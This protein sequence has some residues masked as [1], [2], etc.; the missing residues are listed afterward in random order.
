ML[1]H[2]G[3]R[4]IFSPFSS[5]ACGTGGGKSGGPFLSGG[6]AL[7]PEGK[8]LTEKKEGT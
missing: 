2:S 6:N 5:L 3:V 8:V 4:T 1:W 7:M